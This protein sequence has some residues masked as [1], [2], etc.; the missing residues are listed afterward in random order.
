[1]SLG[2]FVRTW[3]PLIILLA[4]IVKIWPTGKLDFGNTTP[5]AGLILEIDTSTISD[6]NPGVIVAGLPVQDLEGEKGLFI[7]GAVEWTGISGISPILLAGRV[8]DLRLQKVILLQETVELH[9]SPQVIFSVRNL[10]KGTLPVEMVGSLLQGEQLQLKPVSKDT[11]SL[12]VD[13]GP[14]RA[15][16]EHFVKYDAESQNRWMGDPT[17]FQKL[18]QDQEKDDSALL[19]PYRHG[20]LK[21]LNSPSSD[22]V[23]T[24]E[25]R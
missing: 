21:F 24:G 8:D 17:K 10:P 9:R 16:I 7:C 5:W 13:L 23:V 12:V 6:L 14:E 20:N 19:A 11:A 4:L 2:T 15:R 25:G 22:D 18:W 3:L 1:M